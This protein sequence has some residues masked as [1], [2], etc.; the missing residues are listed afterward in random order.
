MAKWVEWSDAD[1]RREGLPLYGEGPFMVVGGDSKLVSVLVSVSMPV[2]W[3]KEASREDHQESI[4]ANHLGLNS[5]SGKCSSEHGTKEDEL[6]PLAG[7]RCTVDAAKMVASPFTK[8]FH[9]GQDVTTSNGPGKVTCV[10]WKQVEVD[11]V[12][13]D[14]YHV[15]I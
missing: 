9:V 4:L 14:A 8:Q 6:H 2:G 11:G 5:C 12:L 15:S 7:Y 1:T 13:Y 10:R 3:L